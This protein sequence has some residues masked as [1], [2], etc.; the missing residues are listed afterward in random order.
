MKYLSMLTPAETLLLMQGRDVAFKE[1]LKIT[2]MDLLIRK[3]LKTS[4]RQYEPTAASNL[5]TLTYVGK[6][7]SFNASVVYPHEMVFLE[8]YMKSRKM[9]PLFHHAVRIG[10]Q[11]SGGKK[12]LHTYDH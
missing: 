11:N 1:L 5:V 7:P 6:G 12:K 4:K 9:N 2:F 8:T 3:Y 10:Y